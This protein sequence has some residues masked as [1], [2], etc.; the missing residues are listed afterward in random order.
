MEYNNSVRDLLGGNLRPAD[1][2]PVDG[3]GGAGFDNNADTLFL[4]PLLMEQYLDAAQTLAEA[5]PASRLFFVKPDKKH[6][7]AQTA[8][9]ILERF[10]FRAFRRPLQKTNPRL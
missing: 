6:S 8:Q 9:I 5:A 2:F 3:A 7:P 1:A 10:A 4:P